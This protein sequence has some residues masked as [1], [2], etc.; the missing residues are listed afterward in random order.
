MSNIFYH[1]RSV[2]P[3]S[4]RITTSSTFMRVETVVDSLYKLFPGNVFSKYRSSFNVHETRI[5]AEAEDLIIPPE[6]SWLEILFYRSTAFWT[7]LHIIHLHGCHRWTLL[8][9]SSRG[10]PV[11]MRSL[12]DTVPAPTLRQP[13]RLPRRL[14]PF[15]PVL[16]RNSKFATALF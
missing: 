11:N 3:G 14:F 9:H 10:C 2:N 4:T 12:A 13:S 16:S 5:F 6:V 15:I 7:F 8:L 1:H